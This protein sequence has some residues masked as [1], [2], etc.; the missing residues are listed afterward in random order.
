VSTDAEGNITT[1]FLGLMSPVEP[2][3]VG[4]FMNVFIISDGGTQAMSGLP[5]LALSGSV[6]IS[7][8]GAGPVTEA[9]PG[10]WRRVEVSVPVFPPFALLALMACFAW[11]GGLALKRPKLKING[12]EPFML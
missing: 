11:A 12:S 7:I 5:C 3:S 1:Y 10:L 8:P 9:P 6:C 2:H 4:T